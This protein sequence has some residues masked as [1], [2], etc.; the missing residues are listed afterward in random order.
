MEL[1]EKLQQL[2]RGRGM[3]Q[4]ELARALFVSRTAIS[5]WESGR[6]YPSIDSLRAIAQF[7]SVTVD[8]LLS[9]DELL[10]LAEEERATRVRRFCDPVFGLLDLAV[11]M[12][13]FLPLFAQR[14]SGAVQ[15][16]SLLSMTEGATWLRILYFV[17]VAASVASGTL[18][19][20]LQGVSARMWERCK[21]W[22]SL[23]CGALGA[24]ILALSLQ[25]YA[26]A[27][28]LAFSAI[29]V[30]MLIKRK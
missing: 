17:L 8:S 26:A 9:G 23:A 21:Y 20:L 15:A 19:L 25:P 12:L 5:K 10:T 11:A 27:F 13:L 24:G 30:S 18:I 3:T 16:V 22:L 1:Q 29:K 7:F 4:E 6:G 2:R 14:A 28:L